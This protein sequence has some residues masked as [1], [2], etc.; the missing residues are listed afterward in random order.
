MKTVLITGGTGGIGEGL[1]RA[2]TRAGWRTAFGFYRNQEK[3]EQ[4]SIQTGA[5]SFSADL[6]EEDQCLQLFAKAQA[7][8]GHIDALILCAGLDWQGLISDMSTAEWDSLIA[9]NLRSAFILSREALGLMQKAGSG[10]ILMISSL[11]AAGGASCESAYA[12]SKAGLIGLCKSLAREWG[13]SGI[14]VNCLAPG[15]IDAGMMDAFNQEDKESLRLDTPLRRLGTPEDTAQAA[16]F[17]SGDQASFITG[18]VLG[19][20]GGL[21]I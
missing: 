9:L 12:S 20:D 10:S 21:L 15:V 19:V 8:L 18:Q 17:L 2:F 13:P 11:Q 7:Q 4:L 6:R 16:L 14:R 5:L 3:A 1:V